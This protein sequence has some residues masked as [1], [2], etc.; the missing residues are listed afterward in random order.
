MQSEITVI[1]ESYQ[2]CLPNSLKIATRI[3]QSSQYLGIKLGMLFKMA[4]SVEIIITLSK[5]SFFT[6]TILDYMQKHYSVAT[7]VNINLPKRLICSTN[8]RNSTLNI[9]I[10]VF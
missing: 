1:T 10:M 3:C 6:P 9:V 8:Y 5:T 7:F 4:K 2:V